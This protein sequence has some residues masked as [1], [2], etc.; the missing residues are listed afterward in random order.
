MEQNALLTSRMAIN[1]GKESGGGDYLFVPVI[2]FFFC[3]CMSEDG[4]LMIILIVGIVPPLSPRKSRITHQQA[5]PP[6]FSARAYA[7]TFSE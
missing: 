1:I 3:D 7:F 5:A 6:G 2:F 4:R